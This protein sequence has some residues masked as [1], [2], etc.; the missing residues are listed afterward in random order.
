MMSKTRQTRTSTVNVFIADDNRMGCQLMAA[1]L[2]RSRYPLAVVGYATNSEESCSTL[3]AND[4]HVA[5][6]GV[7]LKEQAT[8][9]FDLARQVRIAH[10]A[11][12]VIM[13]LDSIE[14]HNVVEA[15]RSGATGVFSRDESFELLCKCIHAVHQGQVWASSKELRFLLELVAQRSSEQAIDSRLPKS[16]T[17]RENEIVHQVAEG[18]T[19][20]DISLQLNLSEH[21]VRNHIFRIFNKLGVSNRLELA[22]YALSRQKED[23]RRG[24]VVLRDIAS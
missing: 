5:V 12:N 23:D 17:K 1:A 11:V 8:A 14:R 15:F 20:R 3:A 22:L 19:N 10:P 6:I 13:I 7:Q 24:N 9:G 21:T 2:R 18:L 4:A 16:L